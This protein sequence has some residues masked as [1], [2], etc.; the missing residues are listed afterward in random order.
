MVIEFE[1]ERYMLKNIQCPNCDNVSKYGENCQCCSCALPENYSPNP[2]LWR[3]TYRH[4]RNSN[5]DPLVVRQL[6]RASHEIYRPASGST[7]EGEIPAI[8][9][10][11]KGEIL[12]KYCREILR[13]Q[14]PDSYPERFDLVTVRV[15]LRR[16]SELDQNFIIKY[17]SSIR[18]CLE[19]VHVAINSDDG[20]HDDVQ[21]GASRSPQME[22]VEYRSKPIIGIVDFGLDFAHEHFLK[23]NKTRIL[24]LWDQSG[25]SINRNSGDIKYGTLYRRKEINAALR[26]NQPYQ[27]LGYEPPVDSLY[28]AGA[29]GTYVADVA[30]GNGYN[31][32]GIGI[33]PNAD[34]IFVD[35]ARFSAHNVVGSRYGDSA[36]LLEAVNFIFEEVHRI[37]E[38][39]G[40]GEI[41]LVINL[42]VGSN[43]GPHD[44]FTSVEIGIDWLI[45]SRDSCAVVV[46]AGNSAD[47]NLYTKGTVNQDS[48]LDLLWY[49][50]PYDTTS[51]EIELWHS[52]K[53]KFA[54]Q[55]LDPDNAPICKPVEC[56][57]CTEISMGSE[58]R[59]MVFN[60]ETDPYN[61]LRQDD[62]Q[63]AAIYV[64]YERSDGYLKKGRWKLRLFA[65][66]IGKDG[67]FDAWIERDERGQSVFVKPNDNS[68]EILEDKTLNSI[69]NGKNTIVVGSY[70][71]DKNSK[72]HKLSTFSSY[73][74]KHH[75]GL[76]PHILAPGES[77]LAARSRTSF[78]RYRQSGTS[79]SAAVVTG[80]IARMFAI[81]PELK[82]SEIKDILKS[83][84]DAPIPIGDSKH[85]IVCL[86]AGN[87]LKKAE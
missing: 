57:K 71:V 76:R 82:Y 64:C 69:A 21:L 81:N 3:T 19:T 5:F 35:M 70:E 80:V 55:I 54:V 52:L 2:D 37:A 7:Q 56:G 11:G 13:L 29:H 18:P 40:D 24:A 72:P 73:N 87:A 25:T 59:I 27:A 49:I 61:D 28:D 8:L 44:G 33:A 23:N 62:E 15:P 41:P 51:N 83:V 1:K 60:R 66:S 65:R 6:V 85:K 10:V 4:E 34:I 74:L 79:L 78:L 14:S 32:G 53:D 12:P 86:N 26:S 58:G 46:A 38:R 84:A 50:P 16:I 67:S 68:Y 22:S 77:I 31:N 47:Q 39:K 36:H 75:D 43:D 48:F 45:E 20:K 63:K 9:R 17:P 42:S 30:A